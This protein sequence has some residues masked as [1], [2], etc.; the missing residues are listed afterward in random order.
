MEV[1]K[2]KFC[3]VTVI[4]IGIHDTVEM[5]YLFREVVLTDD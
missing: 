5:L 2:H 3:A 1:R 4:V